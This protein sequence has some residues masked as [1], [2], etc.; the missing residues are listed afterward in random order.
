[1]PKILVS[2]VNYKD[3]QFIP[4]IE[5][6]WRNAENKDDLIFSLVSEDDHHYD[7]GYIPRNQLI[8]RYFPADIYRGGVAWARNLAVDVD[9]EYDYLIQFDSHTRANYGW[10]TQSIYNYQQIARHNPGKFIIAMGPPSY[11]IA[12]DGTETLWA[13][14]YKFG[15][16]AQDYSTAVPGYGFPT[17]HSLRGTEV[18]QG[19]WA[20][21]MYLVAPKLWVDEVGI[22]K[23]SCFNTE[24]FNLSI[25]TFAKGWK[26]Y[27]IGTRAVF[28]LLHTA[29]GREH[30]KRDRR[31]WG[32]GRADSYWKHLEEATEFLGRLLKGKEDVPLDKVIEFF[33]LANMDKKYLNIEGSY[34]RQDLKPDIPSVGM[35]L[36]RP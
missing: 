28:H 16:I 30:V 9:V 18:I 24:E 36:T 6:L 19:Y 7:F 29:A 13:R 31:P 27:G 8:Y 25:R 1:M 23:D 14:D 15:G 35:P 21:C 32:D 26:I 2:V 20:T 22:A 4:S 12:D 33:E 17:Y 34:I 11:D 5:S 10:D 3:P